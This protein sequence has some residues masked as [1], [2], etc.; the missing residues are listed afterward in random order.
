VARPFGLTTHNAAKAV[1][2]EAD[3]VT[4][5]G[6]LHRNVVAN[7]AGGDGDAPAPARGS[8][9]VHRGSIREAHHFTTQFKHTESGV[10]NVRVLG[11]RRI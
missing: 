10:T 4:S 9:L 5:R 7:G 2:A 1:D 3:L 6:R 11:T 8:T